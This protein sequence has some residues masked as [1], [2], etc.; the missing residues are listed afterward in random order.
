ML[1]VSSRTNLH[2]TAGDGIMRAKGIC[3]HVPGALRADY[4][5][6]LASSDEGQLLVAL[7]VT[8]ARVS[9]R[10]NIAGE[11]REDLVFDGVK[12]AM[13]LAS[14]EHVREFRTR[15]LLYRAIAMLGAG[16]RALDLTVSHVTDRAQFGSALSRKQVVQHYAAEMFGA[17]A[18]VRAACEAAMLTLQ[19]G[20][21]NAALAAALATRIEADR[22]ASI[23]A[24][25]AHQ[26][27]GAIGF[28]EEHILHLSTKR[29]TAWRQDDLGET[30]C[31][32]ELARLALGFGGPWEVMVANGR[33]IAAAPS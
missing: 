12:P 14:S 20:S 1:T 3:R 9:A 18:T 21:G 5:L 11:P 23:V 7:P 15:L 30:A 26:L 31:A 19:A 27:H 6:A 22:M 4:V 28:T 24:R 33:D 2:V 25:L 13:V 29:L 17:L 8:G 32:I 16:E 10:H